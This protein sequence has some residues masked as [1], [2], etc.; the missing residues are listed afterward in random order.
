MGQIKSVSAQVQ[1]YKAQP[2]VLL[3]A[4]VHGDLHQGGAWPVSLR[5]GGELDCGQ[6]EAVH[7]EKWT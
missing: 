7:Q 4:G 2:E 6:A 1:V 3:G 5:R